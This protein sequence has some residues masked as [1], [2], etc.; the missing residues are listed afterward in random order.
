MRSNITVLVGPQEPLLTLS[1]N[2]N[3][4]GMSHAKTASPTPPPHLHSTPH[5]SGKAGL[6]GPCHSVHDPMC[7]QSAVSPHILSWKKYMPTCRLCIARE[8]PGAG[9][10]GEDPADAKRP[11]Q[12]KRGDTWAFPRAEMSARTVGTL[13]VLHGPSREQRCHLEP[14]GHLAC[15]MGLPKR[16]DLISN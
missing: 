13:G 5:P 16:R 9:G 15:H 12:S 4:S 3:G 11:G 2:G 10:G 6:R 8:G 7:P 14:W 1:G